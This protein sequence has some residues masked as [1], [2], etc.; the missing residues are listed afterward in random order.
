MRNIYVYIPKPRHFEKSK[1]ICVTFLFTKIQTLCFTRFFMKFLNLAFIYMQKSWH[2]ALH[3]VFIY[4]NPDTSKKS[5]QYALRFFIY[6]KLTL[7]VMQF[8]LEFFKLVEGG[9]WTK[10]SVLCVKLLYSKNNAL[11]VT[12]LYTK[13]LTLCVTF[14]YAKNNTICVTFLYLK[15]IIYYIIIP[16]YKRPYNQ[17]DQ[18]D[19]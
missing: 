8:F 3:D 18:I 5:R 15:F 12:F 1:T 6:K 4:K 17:S 13:T 10:N 19:K 16:N 9:V 11:S 2:F 14:L 7:C